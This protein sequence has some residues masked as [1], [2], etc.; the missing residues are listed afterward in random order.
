MTPEEIE[1]RCSNCGYEMDG[2]CWALSC[3][4]KCQR[5]DWEMRCKEREQ[6]RELYYQKKDGYCTTEYTCPECPHL[7]NDYD[8]VE[9]PYRNF[10]RS[11]NT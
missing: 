11:D 7:D 2:K 1:E 4:L 6:L 3:D 5:A 8:D 9:I 10:T